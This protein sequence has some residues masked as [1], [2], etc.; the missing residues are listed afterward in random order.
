[1]KGG[2][3]SKGAILKNKPRLYVFD[4]AWNSLKITV[5]ASWTIPHEHSVKAATQHPPDSTVNLG[6]STGKMDTSYVDTYC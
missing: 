4:L 6:G 3:A 5:K 2:V 1:M